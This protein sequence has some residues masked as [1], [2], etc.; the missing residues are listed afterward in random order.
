MEKV[1]V[2]VVTVRKRARCR[3]LL[4][5]SLVKSR[6]VRI[7]KIVYYGDLLQNEQFQFPSSDEPRFLTE[8]LFPLSVKMSKFLF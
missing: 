2:V 7:Q 5:C 1:V 3:Q 8:F 4:A 6:C